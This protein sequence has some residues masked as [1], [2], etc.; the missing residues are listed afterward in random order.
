MSARV[1]PDGSEAWYYMRIVEQDQGHVNEMLALA[2]VSSSS[3][4]YKYSDAQSL[5]MVYGDI[6]SANSS[7][8]GTVTLKR[9]CTQPHGFSG[10]GAD[11]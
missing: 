10:R 5:A 2:G 8:L 7:A 3:K 11:R 6:P 9:H 1:F 4:T